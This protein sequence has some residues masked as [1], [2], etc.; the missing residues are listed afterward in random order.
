MSWHSQL[1]NLYRGGYFMLLRKVNMAFM[2]ATTA[3]LFSAGVATAHVVEC[4]EYPVATM[5]N[6]DTLYFA[7]HYFGESCS[8]AIEEYVACATSYVTPTCGGPTFCTADSLFPGDCY[9]VAR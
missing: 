6:G 7:T 8:E 4:L 1:L 9:V 2:V 5:D 3:F